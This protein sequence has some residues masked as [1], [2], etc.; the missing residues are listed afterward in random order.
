[1]MVSKSS[2]AEVRSRKVVGALGLGQMRSRVQSSSSSMWNEG[3]YGFRGR[4]LDV[5]NEDSKGEGEYSMR[6]NLL[7]RLIFA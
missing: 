1:M 4:V 3:K 5:K 2:K 6:S 7:K